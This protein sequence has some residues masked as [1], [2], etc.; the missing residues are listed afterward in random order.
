VIVLD[1]SVLIAYLHADDDHHD[2]AETLLISVVD[3]DLAADTLTLAEVLVGAARTAQL[4]R[5]QDAINAIEVKEMPFP[6]DSAV[7]LAQL[8][9]ATGLKLP[10]CCV[11][12][13]AEG[14]RASIASFD[15]RLIAAARSR[16]VPVVL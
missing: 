6:T 5:A 4:D 12:L 2:A 8:R 13:A 15:R 10:D 14:A 11:L 9:A 1:A 3:D 7:R 16:N